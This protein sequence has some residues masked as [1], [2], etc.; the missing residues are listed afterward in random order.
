MDNVSQVQLT[1]R[2]ES[3]INMWRPPCDV[4]NKLIWF[5]DRC[6]KQLEPPVINELSLLIY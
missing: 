5:Y 1:D 3:T 6:I 2:A 4:I